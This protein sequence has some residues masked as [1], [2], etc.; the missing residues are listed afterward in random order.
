MAT[1][2]EHPVDRTSERVLGMAELIRTR[3]I[4]KSEV[5]VATAIGK[6]PSTI[7]VRRS[8]IRVLNGADATDNGEV[9]SSTAVTTDYSNNH[10]SLL[11]QENR[12]V[13][14]DFGDAE[15]SDQDDAGL[16]FMASEDTMRAVFPEPLE[17]TSGPI[18]AV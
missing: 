17:E 5:S 1:S 14:R 3:L 11:F 9:I 8:P 7:P 2:A 13:K 10:R 12:V 6:W 15:S 18:N 4:S 16:L